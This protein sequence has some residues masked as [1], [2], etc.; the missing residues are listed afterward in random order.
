M[1]WL[2]LAGLL[3]VALVVVVVITG[4]GQKDGL[5]VGGGLLCEKSRPLARTNSRCRRR[6]SIVDD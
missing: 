6:P 2:A 3:V 1:E 5:G 4:V